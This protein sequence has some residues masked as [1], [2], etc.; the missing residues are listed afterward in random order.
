MPN[1]RCGRC[2]E[3]CGDRECQCRYIMPAG[4]TQHHHGLPTNWAGPDHD[5]EAKHFI[6]CAACGQ[7][8]DCRNLGDVFHHEEPGHAP[9][10]APS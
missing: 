8:I 10:G 6:V 2:G 3:R 5:D 9:I 1:Q 7:A 4:S